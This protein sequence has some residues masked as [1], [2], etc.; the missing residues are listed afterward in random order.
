MIYNHIPVTI[1]C[2]PKVTA[3][4]I[5]FQY[6]QVQILQ[7]GGIELPASYRVD[8]CNP[9]DDATITMVGTADGVQIPNQ[10]LATGRPV[11]AYVVLNGTD[12]NAVETRYQITLPVNKRPPASD[13]EPTPAEQSTIDSLIAAMNDAAEEAEAQA[14]VAEGYAVG[15]QDGEPVPNTSPYYENNAEYM[16]NAA[17]QYALAADAAEGEAAAWATGSYSGDPSGIPVPGDAP[18]HNNNAYFYAQQAAQAV[19]HYPKIVNGYWYVWQN[20]G[21]V[22][23]GVRAEGY[24]G[25]EITNIS[26]A[27]TGTSGLTDTYTVTVTYSSG[28]PDTFQFFV[29]NGQDGVDGYNPVVTITTI[30]GGHRVTI[31]DKAHPSGQTFDVLDGTAG[32]SPSVAITTITGGHRVTI[33]DADHPNGQSFDVMD[34]EDGVSPEV[35]I[36]SITG[37]HTVKI[38]DADH[39]TGQSFNV[40]DGANTDAD[41]VTYDPTETYTAGS[42]GAGLNQL[43]SETNLNTIKLKS[44]DTYPVATDVLYFAN[45]IESKAESAVVNLAYNSNGISGAELIHSN[46]NLLDMSKAYTGCGYNAGTG[47]TFDTT[48][49]D[50]KFT[51]SGGNFVAS[52]LGSWARNAVL[53]NKMKTGSSV[54]IHFNLTAGSVRWSIYVLD[55]QL[56]TT[57]A[58][59]DNK[60]PASSPREFGAIVHLTGD[61]CY[62]A[63]NFIGNAAGFTIQKPTVLYSEYFEDWMYADHKAESY[64]QTFQNQVYGGTY[65]F[66]SGKLISTLDSAGDPL[67][68]P[69]EYDLTGQ[70]VLVYSGENYY[71][72]P[73]GNVVVTHDAN[74]TIVHAETEEKV[75]TLDSD[76]TGFDNRD[77]CFGGILNGDI[78][79]NWLY[80]I[81]S[82][83]KL[84]FPYR[85]R[86]HIAEG[87][88]IGVCYYL[89]NSVYNDSGWVTD[90][91]DIEVDTPFRI[92]IAKVTES[93][94]VRANMDEF[95][96]AV[97]FDTK[98]GSALRQSESLNNR[99]TAVENPFRFKQF[100]SHIGVSQ[101]KN[102]VIIP[103]QSLADVARTKRLGFD[104]LEVNVRAT[105]DG[106]YVCLHGDNGKFGSLFIGANGED[107]SATLVSSVTLDWI[108]TNVRFVSKYDRYKTAPFTLEEMLYEC[109]KLRVIPLVEYKDRQMVELLDKIMGKDNYILSVYNQ[110]LRYESDA[111][112]GS[113]YS[114]NG[115]NVAWKPHLSGRPFIMGVNTSDIVLTDEQWK[116]TAE[117][118][119]KNGY[120]IS[121]A[122]VG[123]TQ[124]Q[125]LFNLGFDAVASS[126][127]I[128]EIENGNICN[129]Y[130]DTDFSDFITTGTVSGGTL[131]LAQNDT[132]V[133]TTV[134]D[135]VFLGGGSL[136]IRF[137]GTISLKFGKNINAL[138]FA[139]DGMSD[140][141][142]STYFEEAIPTFEIT[143]SEATEVYDVTYKAS[144]M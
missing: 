48:T 79:R 90:S 83:N 85:T 89:E 125:K 15:T 21:W 32:V 130:C 8:F 117:D 35:T 29:T 44:S 86:I 70:D 38:T 25:R 22:N 119:H 3:A 67:V 91:I 49:V 143:A 137:D 129:L 50:N 116:A 66:V 115:V 41:D 133:P 88:R 78:N 97:S 5:N 4:P 39:P 141:W 27:K 132:I 60:N 61:E 31:T 128:N 100:F 57:R 140:V 109:R 40:M 6:D 20:N 107:V 75:K 131:T 12:E 69:D 144:R 62:I 98:I 103:N 17:A 26:A 73:A 112:F 134:T 56:K 51:K 19:T 123:E 104:I 65:D 28:D 139:S 102:D 94:S 113:W 114:N 96:A 120:F 18:Q 33:T 80:R 47:A 43:N 87:Y 135:S 16:K 106:E 24:D 14:L 1:G 42:V 110:I 138:T 93:T 59:L 71:F 68:T 37:G 46:R 64:T 76:T 58:S 111:V 118:L 92:T 55:S 126:Y 84:E 11:I 121:T 77:F 2:L 54:V 30:T 36:T 142:F 108:K 23:T 127:A 99:L 105:S 45:G 53:T 74:N 136:H 9:G 7:I 52:T 63:I 122:Y 82:Y 10:L 34:G 95:L 101:N 13:I 124:K 81:V 72:S